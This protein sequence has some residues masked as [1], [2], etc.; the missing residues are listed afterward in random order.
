[1]EVKQ[2]HATD[3]TVR[4]AVTPQNKQEVVRVLDRVTSARGWV[5][6]PAAP[7][8]NELYN[9]EVLYFSYGRN[10]RDM[11][12]TITDIK[13]VSE[14]ELSAFIEG[15]EPGLVEVVVDQFIA[16][17]RAIQSVSSVYKEDPRDSGHAL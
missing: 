12:I 13:N 1:M 8:L 9:R 17:V 10:P 15:S 11:L 6:T 7:G 4:V 16:D 2:Q 3:L 14:L 5:R